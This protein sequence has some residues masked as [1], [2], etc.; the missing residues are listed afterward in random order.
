[1]L[2]NTFEPGKFAF[3]AESVD[4]YESKNDDGSGGAVDFEKSK[5]WGIQ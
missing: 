4:L 2:F 5:R 3:S 1:M